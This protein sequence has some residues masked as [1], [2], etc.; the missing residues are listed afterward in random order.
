MARQSISFTGPNE[1]WLKAQIESEEFTSKSELV[2]DLIRK[3]REKEKNIKW[4]RNELIKGEQSGYSSMSRDE[5]LAQSKKE[6]RQD[7]K[8]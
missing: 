4:L 6:L 8:L 3:A 1:K 5:I 2:N 7:G